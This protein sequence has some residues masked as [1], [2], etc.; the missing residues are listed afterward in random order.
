[1]KPEIITALKLQSPI[2]G[3]IHCGI[4]LDV[5][6]S[7]KPFVFHM[8]SMNKD[9]YLPM[10]IPGTREAVKRNNHFQLALLVDYG[11]QEE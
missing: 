1:M 10:K 3:L 11:F 8:P 4:F 7:L 6:V 5:T 2:L 9:S